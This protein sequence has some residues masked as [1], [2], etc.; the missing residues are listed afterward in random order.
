MLLLGRHICGIHVQHS[1]QEWI[2]L[3][4]PVLN[5][6]LQDLE[7]ETEVL[8]LLYFPNYVVV[9]VIRI[10]NLSYSILM[11]FWNGVKID[12]CKKKYHNFLRRLKYRNVWPILVCITI[13]NAIDRNK[14]AYLKT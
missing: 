13:I 2:S 1:V 10:L 5:Q 7:N 4:N 11:H 9:K 12:V 6:G 14:F 3:K 8:V